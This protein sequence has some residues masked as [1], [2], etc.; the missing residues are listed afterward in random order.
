VYLDPTIGWKSNAEKGEWGTRV[1]LG[2]RNIGVQSERFD[3]Y[4]DD[5]DAFGGVG[6]EAPMK[7]G[8]LRLGLDFVDLFYAD[9][10]EDRVRFGTSYQ[11]GMTEAML[12]V[13][14]R[15]LT[16]GLYYSLSFISA[17]ISYEYLRQDLDQGKPET[18]IATEIAFSL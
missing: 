18:K 12:G 2:V 4:P 9:R 7:Y 14:S 6:V 1:S 13:N 11:V 5:I 8:R 10:I 16:A 15:A 17:G 3:E